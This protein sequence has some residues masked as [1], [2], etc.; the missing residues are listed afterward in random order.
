LFLRS[1]FIKSN[2]LILK[3][4]IAIHIEG[5][6]II[7]YLIPSMIMNGSQTDKGALIAFQSFGLR[8]FDSILYRLSSE[9]ASNGNSGL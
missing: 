3:V 5:C 9:T 7:I 6:I 8:D 2:L 1:Y 4:Y